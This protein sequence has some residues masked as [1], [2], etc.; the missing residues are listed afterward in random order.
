[1]L[2]Q[3]I[4]LTVLARLLPP[5]SYGVMALA[6]IVTNLALLFR[7]MGSS[8]AIIQ[9]NVLTQTL[10]ATVHW[11]NVALGL[12]IGAVVAISGPFMAAV[13]HEPALAKI[14][15]LLAFVFPIGS[16]SIVHQ[17]LLERE[18]RFRLVVTAEVIAALAG[19]TLAILAALF[20]AGVY[21]LVLQV[22][23]S[24]LISTIAIVLLSDFRPSWNWSRRDFNSI[25][26]IRRQPIGI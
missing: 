14:L 3:L 6:T 1:M 5:R 15:Y 19:L 2:A 26:G 23:T 7:D 17:A 8:A 25:R 24:M 20:G 10:K 22:F 9:A 13:F 12:S 4:G 16:F 18:S 11:A 21:S